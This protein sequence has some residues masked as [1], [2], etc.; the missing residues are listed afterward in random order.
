MAL[1]AKDQMRALIDHPDQASAS[2]SEAILADLQQVMTATSASPEQA[3]P[4]AAGDTD[5]AQDGET[6]WN[7]RF[8]LPADAMATGTNPLLLLDELRTLG[9]ASYRL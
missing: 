5:A 7:I 6:T 9:S 1:T 3:E 4:V 8:R 2:A